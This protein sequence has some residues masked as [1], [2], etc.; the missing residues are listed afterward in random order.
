MAPLIRVE[1]CDKEVW[2]INRDLIEFV[3]P[4]ATNNRRTLIV[5]KSGTITVENDVDHVLIT[6]NLI[7]RVFNNVPLMIGVVGGVGVAGG[8][9]AVTAVAV[10]GAKAG[11]AAKLLKKK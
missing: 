8:G 11:A 2:Y 7:A 9:A 4:C 10:K 5:M 1:T 3:R 6:T